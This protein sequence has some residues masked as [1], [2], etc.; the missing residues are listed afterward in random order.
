MKEQFIPLELIGTEDEPVMLPGT[1][2]VIGKFYPPHKGHK[3][4][5]DTAQ[6]NSDALT[7]IV[8][9]RKDQ[10]IPGET[11]KQWLQE[12][13]PDVVVRKFQSDGYPDSDSPLWAK[14]TIGILHYIPEKAFTSEDYGMPWSEAMGNT[15]VLVDKE[16]AR[17]P[18]SG[19]MVRENP[20]QTFDYLEPCVREYFENGGEK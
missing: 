1:G 7:V 20:T 9:E 3:Y 2:V 18:V 14:L 19:T 16:R 17:V 5:I 4:L 13:H 6:A 8:C 12:I 11:R 15:H 10:E